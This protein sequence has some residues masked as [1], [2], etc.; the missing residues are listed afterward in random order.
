MVFG[1]GERNQLAA[2]LS[3][4]VGLMRSLTQTPLMVGFGI[5]TP[6]HAKE[7][8]AAGADGVI[9]GSR[10]VRFIEENPDDPVRMKEQ[11][12]TFIQQV[13]KEIACLKS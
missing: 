12:S 8:A 9:I 1:A 5:S 7:I 3:D 2:D 11:I 10:I 6:E 13:S 4:H